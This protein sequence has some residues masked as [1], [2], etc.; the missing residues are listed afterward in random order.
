MA[1]FHSN[2]YSCIDM[3]VI[4]HGFAFKMAAYWPRPLF[5]FLWTWISRKKEKKTRPAILPSYQ[6]RGPERAIQLHLAR[7]GSQ[8]Q[9]GILF[10]LPAHGASH[11]INTYNEMVQDF[12][13]SSSFYYYSSVSYIYIYIYKV[14]QA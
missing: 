8:S 9:R 12:R 3:G 4:D 5:A 13:D 11:I 10:I 7:L 14:P 1:D 6:A 2:L